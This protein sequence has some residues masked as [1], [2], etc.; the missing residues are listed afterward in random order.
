MCTQCSGTKVVKVWTK[1]I[2]KSLPCGQC[3]KKEELCDSCED[4]YGKLMDGGSWKC[5]KCNGTGLK[6]CK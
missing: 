3:V 4:G 5:D 6:I 2:L 1:G